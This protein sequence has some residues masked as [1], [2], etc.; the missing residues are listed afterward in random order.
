MLRCSLFVL[1]CF[2]G[3]IGRASSAEV[4]YL[5]DIKP[6]FLEKCGA[7]HGALKQEAGLRL[8]AIQLIRKGGDSG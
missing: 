5:R 3:F 8:D 6:I 7:C 4:D 1:A 2:L